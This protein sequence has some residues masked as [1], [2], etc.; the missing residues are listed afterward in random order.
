MVEKDGEEIAR[1]GAGS[2]FGEV[3]LLDHKERSAT[4]QTTERTELIRLDRDRFEQ[5][6]A[7]D[8][9]LAADVFHTFCIY[10]CGRLRRTSEQMAFFKDL[11]AHH[12]A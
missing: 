5:L 10:L 11:A 9:K 3:A 4:V 2:H 1:L 8:H 12:H 6:L 7:S